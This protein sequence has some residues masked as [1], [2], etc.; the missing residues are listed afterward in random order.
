[1]RTLIK[2]ALPAVG[3][4]SVAAGMLP[5]ITTGA[6]TTQGW[7][8]YRQSAMAAISTYRGDGSLTMSESASAVSTSTLTTADGV[9]SV[10]QQSFVATDNGG[11]VD[12]NVT[13][14]GGRQLIVNEADPV[15][16]YQGE[17][18]VLRPGTSS[19]SGAY[20]LPGAS[21]ATTANATTAGLVRTVGHDHGG[22]VASSA[23]AH[24]GRGSM[25]ELVTSSGCGAHPQ[26]PT[27]IGS[28]FGPLIQG[29]GIVSCTLVASMAEIVSLYKGVTHVGNTNTGS[30]T[31][32][33][34][35]IDSYAQCTLIGGTNS[36]HTA[37]L[38]SVNGVVQGG[39]TSPSANL[40]CA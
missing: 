25:A 24:H 11:T 10:A 35:S 23:V 30:G 34:L 6:T 19:V 31:G 7:S 5:A 39:M 38:W 1:M 32:H 8:T 9:I 21:Q 27:V 4:L 13:L 17:T 33:S 28:T 40:N 37:E 22:V 26:T 15:A 29:V 36:F 14:L 16:G 2:A 3:V 12:V 20:A 18:L